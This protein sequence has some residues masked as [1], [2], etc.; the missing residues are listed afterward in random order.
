[1]KLQPST[2]TRYAG[3]FC[4]ARGLSFEERTRLAPCGFWVDG[5]GFPLV[6]KN[7]GVVGTI[8]VSGLSQ[9]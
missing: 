8:S 3:I 5:G 1:M 6:V 9:E 4:L 2:N 7:A